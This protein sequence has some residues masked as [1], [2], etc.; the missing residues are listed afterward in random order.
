MEFHYT[1]D[2][3]LIAQEFK[4][5]P[6]IMHVLRRKAVLSAAK[7]LIPGSL[8]EIGCGS[9]ALLYDF[10]KLGFQCK[11]MDMSKKAIELAKSI[12]ANTIEIEFT[13]TLGENDEGKYD[14]ILAIEVLE[15]N[16]NDLEVLQGW[17]R[18]LKPG[19]HIIVSVPAHP[20]LWS[21][22]DVWAGHC[23]RYSRLS[24]EEVIQKA[25]F[26]VNQTI[27]YGYP[28]ANYLSVIR[29]LFNRL[30]IMIRKGGIQDKITATE[31]S[32]VDRKVE[33]ILYPIYQN[34]LASLILNRFCLKQ[35][36]HYL[37]DKGVG[38]IAIGT[39]VQ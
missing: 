23:R 37:S 31:E 6:T 25:G 34:K 20:E 8:L 9:G 35:E 4:W 17:N 28:L 36:K 15:H 32:G 24:L 13:N 2:Q 21:Y 27:C 33:S 18:F 14:Y 3:G 12:F 26:N 29:N 7:D 10:H 11:G 22:S 38:Y 1:P 16:Q 5:V 19:G 39:K 30:K